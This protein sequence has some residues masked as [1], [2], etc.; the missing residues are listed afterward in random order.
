MKQTRIYALDFDGVICDSAIETGI[1]GWKAGRKL[2]NDYTSALPTSN[3]IEQFR[4]IRPAMEMG[5]EA[6]LVIRLLY[7]GNTVESIL[8]NYSENLQKVID[9]SN[10]D[11]DALKKIFGETRDRWINDDI[12]DWL[13]M[14][15][16]FSGVTEKLENLS[17][18]EIWYIITT[19]QERFVKLIFAA[20]HINLPDNRIFGMDRKM[21]KGAI[22]EN[23]VCKHTA[24]EIIFVEDRLPALLKVINNKKLSSIKLFFALWGYNTDQDKI[25]AETQP[26]KSI[27]LNEFLAVDQEQ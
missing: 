27:E 16:L 1:S 8:N 3:L 6:L 9:K 22:L 21:S 25:E 19:K 11:I 4:Q 23:L 17:R 18:K 13:E 12:D 10:L 15:P 20:N 5:Y 2:W 24:E 26:I 7:D 14:N